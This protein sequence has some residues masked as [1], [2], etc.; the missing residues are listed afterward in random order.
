MSAILVEKNQSLATIT[1]NRSE[2]HNAFDDALISDLIQTLNM[3]RDDDSVRI[4]MLASTGKSFSAGADLTWMQRMI[5]YNYE[6]N[7]ADAEKL[8]QLLFDLYHFPKPTLA[9]IQGSVFGGGVGLVACCDIAISVEHAQFCFSEAKLG[10]IPATIG[11]YIIQALGARASA[12]WFMTAETF[13]AQKAQ[14]LGLLH[15]V[16]AADQLDASC[17]KIIHAILQNG[18]LAVLQCK[19]LVHDLTDHPFD[20]TLI[21]ETARRIATIRVSAEAQTRLA[22]FLEQSKR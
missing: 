3:L 20:R 11:P 17:Q 10:L 12:R 21:S 15:E 6:E 22:A 4:V 19:Q 2:K 13:S 9:K 18:P 1:L 7:C 5:H 14:S 16:V 8:A